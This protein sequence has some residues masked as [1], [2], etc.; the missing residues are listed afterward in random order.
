M[1]GSGVVAGRV[2]AGG[3]SAGTAAGGG[4]CGPSNSFIFSIKAARAAACA[5][6]SC[7]WAEIK[8]AQIADAQ[9]INRDLETCM[10]F[11]Y[12]NFP[13]D[14][15]AFAAGGYRWRQTNGSGKAR[16]ERNKIPRT[17]LRET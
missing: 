5:G 10:M 4:V 3:G 13:P 8:T 11:F 2:G 16:I 14:A 9:I 17:S 15:T 12:A 7:A 1:P 6:L